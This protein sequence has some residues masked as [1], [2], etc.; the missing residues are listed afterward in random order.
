M[1]KVRKPNVVRGLSQKSRLEIGKGYDAITM[2]RVTHQ[3]PKHIATHTKSGDLS[4]TVLIE[5]V[6][7][8]SETCRICGKE[9]SLR[10]EYYSEAVVGI[11]QG[12]LIHFSSYCLDCGKSSGLRVRLSRYRD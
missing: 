4:P 5:K 7:R 2:N 1:S 8:K 3:L 9:I 11:G 10:Q 6:A 12:P